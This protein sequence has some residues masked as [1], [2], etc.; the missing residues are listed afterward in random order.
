MQTMTRWQPWAGWDPITEMNEMTRRFSSLLGLAPI[1][2]GDGKEGTAPVGAWAPLV[3]ITED[4]TE[5]VITAELPGIRK[6]E[7]AVT[8]ENGVLNFSGER[9]S[10]HD[11]KSKRCHR[12]ERAYGRFERSFTLPEDADAQKVSAE[13]KDGVLRI[14]LPKDTRALPR[15]VDVKVS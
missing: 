2:H 8:V 9:K 14:H 5:Y 6:E 4:G 13:Y 11:E 7:V 10:Q 3:D 15:S 12:I 1:R